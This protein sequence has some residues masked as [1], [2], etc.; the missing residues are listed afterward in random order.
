M[1]DPNVRAK[2]ESAKTKAFQNSIIPS[3]TFLCGSRGEVDDPQF[4][5]KEGNWS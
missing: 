2:L 4:V 5:K 3:V 1:A